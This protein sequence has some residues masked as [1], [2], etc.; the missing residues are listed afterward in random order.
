MSLLIKFESRGVITRNLFSTSQST[1]LLR[2]RV[3]SVAVPAKVVPERIDARQSPVAPSASEDRLSG[4][5]RFGDG[6]PLALLSCSRGRVSDTHRHLHTHR[7][8]ACGKAG[9]ACNFSKQASLVREY[10]F[11]EF[12]SLVELFLQDDVKQAS[13]L[14]QPAS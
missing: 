3:D 10:S 1:H 4:S 12:R 2:L 7:K 9:T 14:L 5:A 8:R 6:M 13:E 11:R